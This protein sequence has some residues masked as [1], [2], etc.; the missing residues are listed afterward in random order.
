MYG[1]TMSVTQSFEVDFG[2]KELKSHLQVVYLYRRTI[3][4]GIIVVLLMY[5]P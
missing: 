3:A 5:V 4:M 1:T 2:A